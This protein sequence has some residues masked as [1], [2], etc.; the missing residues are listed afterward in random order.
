M[1]VQWI[2]EKLGI[3]PWIVTVSMLCLAGLLFWLRY[4]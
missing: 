3:S 1:I 2:A 4:G